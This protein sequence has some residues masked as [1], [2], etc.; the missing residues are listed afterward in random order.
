MGLPE[1][2]ERVLPS[3]VALVSLA[4][5]ESL[6][7][8]PGHAIPNVLGTGFVVD[9]RGIVLTAAHVARSLRALPLNPET[10]RH[11]AAAIVFSEPD[12]VDGGFELRAS[13]VEIRK[14]SMLD[15]FTTAGVFYGEATPDIAFVQLAVRD[16]PAVTFRAEPNTL[17]A[18]LEVAFAGFPLG[19]EALVL[20]LESKPRLVQMMPFL[21]HGI[22]SSVQPFPCPEPHGFTVDVMSHGGASGA[23]IFGWN[24]ER[25]LGMLYAAFEGDERVTY[26][27]PDHLLRWATKE[28][29]TDPTLD[30][31]G[32][33]TLAEHR[34]GTKPEG[35]II[36]RS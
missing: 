34:A 7:F 26:A 35:W 3:V 5:P 25:V 24:D 2:F 22:I 18:G 16:L 9:S 23:P 13:W 17:R 32:V 12:K 28:A 6:R 29:L 20:R 19:S 10:G 4:I 27:L 1:T 8:E 11:A 14:Y 33:P 31:S 36:P 30:F 15:N 21:R